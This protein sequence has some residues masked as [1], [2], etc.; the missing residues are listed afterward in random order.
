ME[1]EMGTE[2][3]SW[4]SVWRF[5]TFS[6]ATKQ[7][8]ILLIPG[9]GTFWLISSTDINYLGLSSL[10][11]KQLVSYC[12]IQ[13]CIEKKTNVIK[14][15]FQNPWNWKRVGNNYNAVTLERMLVS[16]G[17]PVQQT[18][19]EKDLTKIALQVSSPAPVPST[20][21]VYTLSL[22]TMPSPPYP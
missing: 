12:F 11:M 4:I 8:W 17:S 6:R 14:V 10:K 13:R 2:G 22:P 18:Q 9:I 19:T 7:S 20:L 3:F 15:F 21:P 16:W 1:E 5:Y